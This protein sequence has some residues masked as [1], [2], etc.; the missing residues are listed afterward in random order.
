MPSPKKASPKKASPKKASPKKASPKRVNRLTTQPSEVLNEI[1]KKLN[2]N[3]KLRVSQTSR[4]FRRSSPLK[5]ARYQED[6]IHEGYEDAM[7]S[8]LR[9]A[10]QDSELR[11]D[12]H[13]PPLNRAQRLLRNSNPDNNHRIWRMSDIVED[14]TRKRDRERGVLN[15]LKQTHQRVKRDRV[16]R[17]NFMVAGRRIKV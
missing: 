9:G 16:Q 8:A 11:L 7:L 2:H 1:W 10:I 12:L 14:L 15:R 3:S 5:R 17:R 13:L 6:M 4:T